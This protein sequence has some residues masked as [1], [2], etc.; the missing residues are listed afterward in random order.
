MPAVRRDAATAKRFAR[1]GE[2]EEAAL[3][4]KALR[5]RLAKRL[6]Q[7]LVQQQLQQ[8]DSTAPVHEDTYLCS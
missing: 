7:P 3:R 8:V 4:R 5:N 1:T 2:P 6:T